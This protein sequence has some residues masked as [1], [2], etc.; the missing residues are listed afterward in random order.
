MNTLLLSAALRNNVHDLVVM[1]L[2]GSLVNISWDEFDST[3]IMALRSDMSACGILMIN[4]EHLAHRCTQK[5]CNNVFVRDCMYTFT[6]ELFT[7]GYI[8]WAV[9]DVR[10][11]CACL[12]YP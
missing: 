11:L 6:R 8:R 4:S 1:F 3:S 5:V 10:F 7:V 12:I 2:G 9:E